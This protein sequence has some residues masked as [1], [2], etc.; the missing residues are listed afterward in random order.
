MKQIRVLF[1]SAREDSLLGL[2]PT[3]R[4]VERVFYGAAWSTLLFIFASGVMVALLRRPIVQ[5]S[6]LVQCEFA[7]N[8]LHAVYI[9]IEPR[10][11]P[12]YA[13]LQGDLFG[14]LISVSALV[15]TLQ[16]WIVSQLDVN[17]YST[18][19]YVRMLRSKRW[20]EKQIAARRFEPLK[21]L[22]RILTDMVRAGLGAAL[23][24]I[25]LGFVPSAWA[26]VSCL[27]GAAFMVVGSFCAIQMVHRNTR[28]YIRFRVWV[29]SN[30]LDETET[31][32]R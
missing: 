7:R 15:L 32:G 26:A 6:W 2:K 5:P 3:S 1:Q 29:A 27:A 25:T 18:P 11:L 28:Q 17:L 30:P 23:I 19:D 10:L 9:W 12:V 16:T 31:G 20:T 4:W 14:G 22:D 24:Q 8:W 21:R 13:G